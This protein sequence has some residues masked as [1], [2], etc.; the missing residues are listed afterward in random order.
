[1]QVDVEKE[2][3][4]TETTVELHRVGADTDLHTIIA[5][6]FVRRNHLVH[7]IDLGIV[8][9]FSIRDMWSLEDA[10]AH[11]TAVIACIKL[12]ESRITKLAPK[13]FP[14]RLGEDGVEE[15]DLGKL[16]TR[17]AALETE[18]K[19]KIERYE[20]SDALWNE[21]LAASQTARAKELAYL[22]E[23]QFLRPVRHLDMRRSFQIELLK[24]RMAFLLLLKSELDDG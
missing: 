23:A 24:T 4:N 7:E 10:A 15:D 13:D 1:L 16:T 6:L 11:A 21:A 3:R 14:N 18:I 2:L 9:H 19:E 22:D 17:V 8:G 5:G 20:D 12:I